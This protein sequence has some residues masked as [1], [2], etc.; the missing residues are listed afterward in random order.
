MVLVMEQYRTFLKRVLVGALSLLACWAL[1]V[2][3]IDPFFHYHT[4]LFGM[5]P[6]VD[7]ER[8]QNPGIAEHFEYDSIILGSS[9]TENFNTDWFDEGFSCDSVKLPFSAARTGSY[10]WMMQK[11]FATREVKNVF[12]GLDVDSLISAFGTYFFPLP[13]YLY[14]ENAFNDVEYLLNKSVLEPTVN[15][16]KQNVK[17]T[18]PPL[19]TAYS[20]DEPGIYGKEKALE[21]VTW[22]LTRQ[23]STRDCS[24][25]LDNCRENLEGDILPHIKAHPETDFYIFFP[26]YSIL[27]WNLMQ[28]SG[29]TDARLDTVR[30]AMEL[31]LPYENVHLYF[32]QND[33]DTICNL[34]NYKDF[35]HYSAEIS[36]KI[37][38]WLKDGKGLVTRE[39]YE[40]LL[41]D[42]RDLAL[43]YDYAALAEEKAKLG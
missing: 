14:D 3:V 33:R 12:I 5:K 11:A 10:H 18:V 24:V 21:S 30:Q 7:N 16:L 43:N 31:L 37:V 2:I 8:Y 27:W 32:F 6:L 23:E 13:E 17:G 20:W 1:M 29:E 39:N 15:L 41:A 26:P 22:D 9:M 19:N 28:N 40:A 34:D 42:M 25:F 36:Q 35:N 38:G 4:P